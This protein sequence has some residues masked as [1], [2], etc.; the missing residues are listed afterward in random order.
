[1]T[2]PQPDSDRMRE[3]LERITPVCRTY[4]SGMGS[5]WRNGRSPTAE[6]EADQCCAGCL[7]AYGLGLI[8][9]TRP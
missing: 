9:D 8:K 6:Y 1:M 3:A 4:T 5:C 2:E 7:A